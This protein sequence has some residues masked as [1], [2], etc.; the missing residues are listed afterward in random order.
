[1]NLTWKE[2]SHK[3]HTLCDSICNDVLLKGAAQNLPIKGHHK[4]SATGK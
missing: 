4:D 3:G 1:M 2:T